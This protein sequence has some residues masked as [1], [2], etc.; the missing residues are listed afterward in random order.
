MLESRSE[1]ESWWVS[2]VIIT[3]DRESTAAWNDDLA[4]LD[5]ACHDVAAWTEPPCKEGPACD[6][7]LAR[8][9]GAAPLVNIT[10]FLVFPCNKYL[11]VSGKNGNAID[12]TLVFT[13]NLR[14]AG[15]SAASLAGGGWRRRGRRSII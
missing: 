5:T 14:E 9:T 8:N 15:T 2:C 11:S 6:E 7:P 1:S 4:F 13:L 3:C 10:D 12:T